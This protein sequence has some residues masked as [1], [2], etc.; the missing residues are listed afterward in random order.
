MVEAVHVAS[1]ISG[2]PYEPYCPGCGARTLVACASCGGRIR[3]RY[4]VDNVIFTNQRYRPPGFCDLCGAAHPWASRQQRIWEIENLL[5]REGLSEAEELAL[6]EKF[7]ELASGE[8][9]ED[10]QVERWKFIKAAVPESSN[11]GRK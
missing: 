10:E 4:H 11:L 2:R 1:R 5:E 8:L 6:R 9:D 7:E 3:G